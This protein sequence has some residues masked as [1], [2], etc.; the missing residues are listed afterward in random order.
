MLDVSSIA[1]LRSVLENL[2]AP[3]ALVSTLDDSEKGRQMGELLDEVAAVSAKVT[4]RRDGADTRRPSF[5]IVRE[6][7]PSVFVTFA[8]SPLGHEFPSFILAMLHVSGHPPRIEEGT[9]VQQVW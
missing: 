7:E 8:G 6:A 3:I 2:R 4:H 1:Q 9:H 5:R